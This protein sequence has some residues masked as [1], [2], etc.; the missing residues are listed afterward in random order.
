MRG[1][2]TRT[3]ISRGPSPV[4]SGP[5]GVGSVGRADWAASGVP[6]D[7]DAGVG[8]AV[9]D[10]TATVGVAATAEATGGMAG[11]GAVGP[12]WPVSGLAG[13]LAQPVARRRT[14]SRASEDAARDLF[15]APEGRGPARGRRPD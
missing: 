14:A 2:R 11:V 12:A 9:G 13:R 8:T 10:V 3:G 6:V 4:S 7:S 1:I 5:A 15:I